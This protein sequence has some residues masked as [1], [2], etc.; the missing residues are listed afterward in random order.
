[1]EEESP[2]MDPRLLELLREINHLDHTEWVLS[3]EDIWI[4]HHPQLWNQKVN[5]RKTSLYDVPDQFTL[6]K[7]QHCINALCK[8]R[9]DHEKV[10]LEC[11]RGIVN[12]TIDI[13]GLPMAVQD[14]VVKM[15]QDP[16]VVIG[17]LLA[18][19]GREQAEEDAKRK[20]ARI[21]AEQAVAPKFELE[22]TS[23]S[24]TDVTKNEQPEGAANRPMKGATEGTDI[25]SDD[26][27]TDPAQVRVP[28][29]SL[30]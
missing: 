26:T 11:S 14:D 4:D 8:R 17:D 13:R 1:M 10:L 20:A 2:S 6:S 18:I 3:D 7:K 15:C 28:R 29:F 27:Q 23:A 9:Q 30:N 16:Y 5:G 21:A 25:S 19:I 22:I 12:G 24:V